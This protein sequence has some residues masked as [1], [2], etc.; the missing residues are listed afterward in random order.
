MKYIRILSLVMVTI[1]ASCSSNDE[2]TSS[3]ELEG[4]TKFK[5]IENA[6]HTI[7]IYKHGGGLEQ[8]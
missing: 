1:F 5:E 4:L 7:E 3:D 8:G 2:T 6:T